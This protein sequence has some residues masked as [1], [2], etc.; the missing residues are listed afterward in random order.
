[1]EATRPPSLSVLQRVAGL[2]IVDQLLPFFEQAQKTSVIIDALETTQAIASTEFRADANVKKLMVD[3]LAVVKRVLALAPSDEESLRP[4]FERPEPAAT[5]GGMFRRVSVA[6]V[7]RS[8]SAMVLGASSR[9]ELYLRT[10]NAL[11]ASWHKTLELL[12]R[13]YESTPA[14]RATFQL[15]PA[16]LHVLAFFDRRLSSIL[17]IMLL[18]QPYALQSHGGH[19]MFVLLSKLA[20]KPFENPAVSTRADN[21]VS[22]LMYYNA[23]LSVFAA[24]CI[25][26]AL[27]E[28]R[29]KPYLC[30]PIAAQSVF[31]APAQSPLPRVNFGPGFYD[32]LSPVQMCN[33][34]VVLVG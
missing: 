19:V 18:A 9:K 25:K 14:A 16:E 7:T 26:N 29:G 27:E 6:D 5:K 12:F 2:E 11:V 10:V 1:M 33:F 24:N 21:Y 15:D 31:Y 4:F 3:A 34:S 22:D 13:Y 28:Q 30:G 32:R 23:V 8:F 17:D 20:D